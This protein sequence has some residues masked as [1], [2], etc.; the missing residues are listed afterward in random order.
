VKD[1]L[2]AAESIR[3]GTAGAFKPGVANGVKVRRYDYG[4][5]ALIVRAP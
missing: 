3:G 1:V 2:D 4:R 5:F